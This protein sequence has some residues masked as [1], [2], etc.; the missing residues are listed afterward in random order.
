[1]SLLCRLA[2]RAD[3]PALVA[4]EEGTFHEDRLSARSFRQL[5]AAPSAELIVAEEGGE[6]LGYALLLFRRG[7]KVA[8]LYS[9]ATSQQARGRGL[10]SG[11]LEQAERSTAR[12]GCRALRLEVRVDNSVAIGLYERRGYRRFGQIAGFYEDG[13]DAWRYEKPLI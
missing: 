5:I 4:L 3:F 13:A 7:T 9:L 10:G 6:L 1:M 2:T 8:R 12:H 11:L